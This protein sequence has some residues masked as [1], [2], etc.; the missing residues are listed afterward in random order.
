[1]TFI[2]TTSQS[3]YNPIRTIV[4]PSTSRKMEDIDISVQALPLINRLTSIRSEIKK[5]S[6]Y[7]KLATYLVDEKIGVETFKKKVEEQ[8]KNISKSRVS[9]ANSTAQTKKLDNTSPLSGLNEFKIIK[10][11][12][13]KSGSYIND[14]LLQ[15]CTDIIEFVDFFENNPR[16]VQ[17]K[18]NEYSLRITLLKEELKLK[19]AHLKKLYK[20]Y[21]CSTEKTSDSKINDS[22][23]TEETSS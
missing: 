13:L 5:T 7:L 1:M 11:H 14:K 12:K 15:R 16:L 8:L 20:D 18:I 4:I 2:S 21:F 10:V 17:I 23:E 9:R 22:S 3:T 19:T 6:N